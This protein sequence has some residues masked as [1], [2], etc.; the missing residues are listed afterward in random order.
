[1]NYRNFRLIG[2]AC[3]AVLV[4]APLSAQAGRFDLEKTKTIVS[5]LIEKA[6]KE[7][8]VPSMSIALVRGDS[9]VWK[10]AFG[11]A[12]VR[13]K[14][15]ATTET[16]YSTGSTFKSAT[17]TALMQLQEQGKFK[18][19]QP[20]NQYLGDVQIQDRLQSEKA[21]TFRHM[22]S[23]W[24]GLIAGA[25]TKPLW[26]RELPKS[27]DKMVS[28]LYSVRAPEAK[29]EYNNF[30]FGMAGLLVEKISGMEY[31]KYMVENVLKP[32]GITTP[33]PVYPSAE[34][35]EVMALPYSAGGPTGKPQPVA[36]VHFDVYPAGDIYLTA[37]DMA[38]FLAMHLNGGVF[39]GHRILSE[40]S[41]KTMH[42]PQFGGTYAFGFS[43]KK[44]ANGHTIISH[45][46]GIP[47]QSSYM[48][49]DV[50]AKVGVY[51]M[52]NS[53]GPPSIAEAALKL[54][55]GEEYVPPPERKSIAVDPAVLDTYVGTYELTPD[56]VFT[57]SRVGRSLML[58][59][60]DAPTKSELLADSPTTF[61]IK[62]Q[63]FTL[64]FVANAAGAIEKIVLDTGSDKL[65]AKR[66]K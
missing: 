54:L 28:G 29:W 15:P 42:E 63:D 11:Y 52:S 56:V 9:I 62:G 16:I 58:Q 38:R 13:T 64:T 50:D 49:G 3:A 18:L 60:G 23:H 19:D 24:S 32:L 8:G 33:H 40:A 20:V 22:L 59:Q 45:S 4:G 7:R 17:A 65:D 48:V 55:R 47:G 66:R 25:A 37:E 21:V 46:G 26:G 53:G 36:Q 41:V 43:V 31:E 51:F 6:L 2:L 1:M 30:A 39:Q 10:A 27:L 34:M 61:Y 5:G 35:V 12:N 44:E 14:T 57:V